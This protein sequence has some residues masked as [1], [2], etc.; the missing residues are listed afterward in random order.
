MIVANNV[1]HS[2]VNNWRK[3]GAENV[4]DYEFPQE[5]K[6]LHDCLDPE[7]KDEQVGIV[8]PILLALMDKAANTNGQNG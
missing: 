2:P 1:I 8:Y 6:F 4:L 7:Q 3:N 5:M